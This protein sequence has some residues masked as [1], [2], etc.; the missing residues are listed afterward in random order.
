MYNL[1]LFF[2]IIDDTSCRYIF[3]L[4]TKEMAFSNLKFKSSQSKSAKFR[5]RKAFWTSQSDKIICNNLRILKILI[6]KDLLIIL[7]YNWFVRNWYWLYA[8]YIQFCSNEII[9][10]FLMHFINVIR[11]RARS[12]RKAISNYIFSAWNMTNFEVKQSNL[13]QLSCE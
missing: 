2:K 6:R 1:G 13:Y 4:A 3:R 8:Q 5:T 10:V 11:S 9:D 12:S 7:V